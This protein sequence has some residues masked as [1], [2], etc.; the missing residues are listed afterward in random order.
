M[1]AGKGSNWRD[2]PRGKLNKKQTIFVLFVFSCSKT[3]VSPTKTTKFGK[4][5]NKEPP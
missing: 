4:A 5:N 3:N 1:L 2:L